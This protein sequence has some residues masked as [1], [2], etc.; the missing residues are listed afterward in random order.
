VQYKDRIRLQLPSHC[1]VKGLIQRV[2]EILFLARPPE[3]L[4]A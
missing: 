2:T 4:L 1:P 3:P